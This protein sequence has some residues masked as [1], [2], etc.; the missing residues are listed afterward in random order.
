MYPRLLTIVNSILQAIQSYPSNHAL[1]DP[2]L[3]HNL[4]LPFLLQGHD[5]YFILPS[6]FLDLDLISEL[7]IHLGLALY[8]WTLISILL[9]FS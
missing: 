6:H 4:A 5:T 9:L 1:A 3:K 7:F 2:W 8:K